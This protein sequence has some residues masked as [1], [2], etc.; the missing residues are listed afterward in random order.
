[1]HNAVTL[2]WT[3]EL[4]QA[5]P[6]N[7]KVNDCAYECFDW[8]EIHE[9]FDIKQHVLA[10]VDAFLRS[11]YVYVWINARAVVYLVLYIS[12]PSLPYIAL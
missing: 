1:M 9:G 10:I 4:T 8:Q 7:M 2:V 3:V 12:I 11:V 6:M 5:R